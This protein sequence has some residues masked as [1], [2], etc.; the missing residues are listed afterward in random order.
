[1]KWSI[2]WDPFCYKTWGYHI[3][4]KITHILDWPVKLNWESWKAPLKHKN[5]TRTAKNND[6][7]A[8]H[9]H[10]SKETQPWN[11]RSDYKNIHSLKAQPP[12]THKLGEQLITYTTKVRS[13]NKNCPKVSQRPCSFCYFKTASQSQKQTNF[14]LRSPKLNDR[15]LVSPPVIL[16][17]N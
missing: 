12:P 3:K 16:K 6:N 10:R 2:S 9:S 13:I 17:I 15:R 4:S 5:S 8:H 7:R 11:H 14:F 1:M